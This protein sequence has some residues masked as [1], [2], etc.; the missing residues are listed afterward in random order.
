MP[1]SRDWVHELKLDGYRLQVHVRTNVQGGAN[2]PKVRLFTRNGL[3]WTARMPGIARAAAELEVDSVILDGEV[4]VLDQM[5]RSSFSDLQAAFQNGKYADLVYFAFDILHLNGR[6]LRGLPLLTR[7]EIL[8][9]LLST[10][11]TR[12]GSCDSASISKAKGDM[13]FAKACELG[14]EGIVSKLV[15]APYTSGRGST[16]LKKK[17]MLKQEFVI[18]GFTPVAKT[19]R[20]I[21][22]LLLGYYEGGRLLYAG[23]C[24]TGFSHEMERLLRVRLDAL[25]QK[26]PSLC[27]A[28]A[29]SQ[30]E[31]RLGQA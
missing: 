28:A 14:A 23:R 2:V 25:V 18:G 11:S 27:R 24:G 4:V 13:V 10:A 26:A 3:D 9:K 8:E 12:F 20:G 22:A 16:W 5:G 17:G 1:V 7:K 19:G 30:R 21:G 29:R 6:N 31:C 15:S